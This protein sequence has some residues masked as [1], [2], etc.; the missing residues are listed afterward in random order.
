MQTLS[1]QIVPQLV[2]QIENPITP[3]PVAQIDKRFADCRNDR[4]K[5]FVYKEKLYTKKCTRQR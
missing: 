2:A 3:Q 5:R 1:A 4:I